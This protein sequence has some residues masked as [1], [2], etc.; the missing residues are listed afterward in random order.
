MPAKLHERVLRVPFRLASTRATF[1][2]YFHA[3]SWGTAEE[4]VSGPASSLER[5]VAIRRELPGLLSEL[6]ARSLLDIPCGDFH[7]MS[8][9]NLPLQEY[10]GADI[11]DEL[12]E[13]NRSRHAAAGRRFEVIDLITGPLPRA[14]VVLCRDC[15]VH[16][17][18]TKALHA[19]SNI[20]ASGSTWLLATTF[21]GAVAKNR[22][23]LTGGWRMLDLTLP[24]FNFPSPRCEIDEE[25][26][27][28]PHKRLA[29]W[30]ISELAR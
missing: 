18:L 7:W 6:G 23:T 25:W 9:A 28:W 17:S 26:P 2:H 20:I 24:P 4:S 19:V 10:I 14:D 29:L 21:P 15:L 3:R 5:T 1:R 22:D 27:Q 16:L 30:N 8:H 11:V 13:A 12:I